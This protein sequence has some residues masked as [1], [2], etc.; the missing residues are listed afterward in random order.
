MGE[1]FTLTVE[2]V[3]G[4]LLTD[5]GLWLEVEVESPSPPEDIHRG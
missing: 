2:T 4:V 1:T 3:E 5:D